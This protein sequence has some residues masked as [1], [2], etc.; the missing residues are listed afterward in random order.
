MEK[1]DDVRYREQLFD[2]LANNT[3]DVFLMMKTDDYAIEY[4]SPNIER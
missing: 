4:V 1:E 3:N 2:I